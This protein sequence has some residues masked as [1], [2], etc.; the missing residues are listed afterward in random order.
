M[1]F[2]RL[3]D[4]DVD[5]A[6][7]VIAEDDV[8]EVLPM[9]WTSPETVARRMEPFS[10]PSTFSI[11]VQGSG[12]PP[13]HLGRLEYEGELHFARAEELADG[14][15]AAEED[16]VYDGEG[17]VLF[18]GGFGVLFRGL[19]SRRQRCAGEGFFDGQPSNASDPC[20][21]S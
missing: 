12:P 18:E 7:A 20:W 19:S 11:R 16:V 14:L 10:E 3:L 1:A 21:R 6:V 2:D 9:S 17:L 13:H 4:A 5:H 15:H 8:D